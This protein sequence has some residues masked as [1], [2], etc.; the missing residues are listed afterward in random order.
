MERKALFTSSVFVIC[1]WGTGPVL[2]CTIQR[3]AGFN[4][5]TCIHLID[6]FKADPT[7]SAGCGVI[8]FLTEAIQFRTLR[9]KAG[10]MVRL[11]IGTGDS[12]YAFARNPDVSFLAQFETD[13]NARFI[14]RT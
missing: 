13:E 7:R 14:R 3:L 6:F 12:T 10:G 11:T 1:L 4:G 8:E 5:H 9:C 2:A